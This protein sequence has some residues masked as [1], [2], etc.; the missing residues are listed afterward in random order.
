[1]WWI[2]DA[3]YLWIYDHRGTHMIEN[4]PWHGAVLVRYN[5]GAGGCHHVQFISPFP[6]L[7]PL[8]P[9]FIGQEDGKW[10]LGLLFMRCIPIWHGIQGLD[11]LHGITS[12][13][14]QTHWCETERECGI[15]FVTVLLSYGSYCLLGLPV[16]WG[17]AGRCYFSCKLSL[18]SL[19]DMPDTESLCTWLLCYRSDS[20]AQLL[21]FR[22]CVMV[23]QW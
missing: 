6:P 22:S 5:V 17:W 13:S 21:M 10:A 14:R 23:C 16:A 18:D 1:M 2:G 20:E 3:N 15:P 12:F 9:S 7:L 4:F 19:T 8:A 11:L